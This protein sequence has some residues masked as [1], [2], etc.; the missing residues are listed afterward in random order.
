MTQMPPMPQSPQASY[1][2]GDM[3]NVE[4]KA[5]LIDLIRLM[6][7]RAH[8]ITYNLF[9]QSNQGGGPQP[10]ASTRASRIWDFKR[11]KSLTFHGTKV[12]EGTQGFIDE[13][14]NVVDAMG[15]TPRER[16]SG[17]SHLSTQRC[18]SSVV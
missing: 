8:V 4:L 6:M 13:V 5:S 17:S 14:L 12:D 11:I 18:D 15:V 10:N 1:V 2:E 9:S 3:A 16:E 7:T